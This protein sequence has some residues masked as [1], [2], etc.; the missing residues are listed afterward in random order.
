MNKDDLVYK[1]LVI[2]DN[3]GDFF[4]IEENLSHHF[5]S[6]EII[7]ANTY[8]KAKEFLS[9]TSN[10]F[11][12]IFLDLTLPDKN[13][14][15]LIKNILELAKEIPV[16]VLTGYG[17]ISFGIKSLTLGVSD[18]LNKD[19]LNPTLLHKSILYNIERKK[20]R[21]ELEESKNRYSDLFHLSPIPMWVFDLET[22]YFLDVNDAAIE[23]YG[24]SSDEFLAMTIE[25]I[26]PSEE[27]A[28]MKLALENW[29]EHKETVFKSKFKHLK[30]NRTE[31]EVEI[32]STPIEFKGRKAKLIL[33][34]DVTEKNKYLKAIE[35]Q[36]TQL[37]EIAW[38]QSHQVRAPVSR[39]L[40]IVNYI[41]EY[42]LDS[43]ENKFFLESLKTSTL[44]LDTIIR[45]ISSKTNSINL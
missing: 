26:R 24:Y 31:I 32:Q 36:N 13:G 10:I 3:L 23:H 38:I 14:E 21:I 17:D 25:Q 34:N 1:I 41:Q 27:L 8:N 43:D 28:R 9:D 16:I 42:P 35:T 44:E 29:Y 39:I 5:K 45:E 19:E 30:K 6:S 4:L 33:S 20:K 22:L 37:K 11:T 18:Y 12:I 7:N 40:G 2:E 15:E